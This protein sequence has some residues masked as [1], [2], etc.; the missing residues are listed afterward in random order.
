[1]RCRTAHGSVVAILLG[2]FVLVPRSSGAATDAGAVTLDAHAEIAAVLYAAS[3]T[4]AAVAKSADER[5][6]RQQE[7]IKV[8][9]AELKAGDGRHRAEMIAAQESFVAELAQRDREYA[10]QIAVFRNAVNDIASTPDGAKAL[11]RFNAGDEVGAIAILDKLRSTNE[12]MRQAQAKLEDAADARRIARLAL[13]AK[14]RGKLTT[15]AVILRFE[16]VVQLDPGVFLDWLELDRLYQDAGRLSDARKAVESLAAAARDDVDRALGFSELSDVLLAMGDLAGARAAA[17]QSLRISRRLS[18]ADPKNV[19]LEFTFSHALI[20]F[21]EVAR[22]QGDLATAEKSY[23]EE[24]SIARKRAAADPDSLRVR[25]ALCGD[26]LHLSDVLIQRG[27]LAGARTALEETLT[28]LRRMAA[29]D[30]ENIVHQRQ[31]S[32]S[33]MWLSDVLVSLGSFAEAQ[34]SNAEI[35]AIA[36]RLTAAD[37][38]NAILRRDLSYG[39][40]K[41]AFLQRIDGDF[42]GSL[43]SY[44]RALQI[45]RDLARSSSAALDVRQDVGTGLA[46]VANLK[47]LKQDF[48]GARQSATESVAILRN[49]SAADATD[50]T[51]RQ[52]Q[53][54][55]LYGLG[56]TL[57]ATSDPSGARKAYEE[58]LALDRALATK[59]ADASDIQNDIALGELGLGKLLLKQGDAVAA[60]KSLEHCLEIRRRMAALHAGSSST[61]RAVAEVMRALVDVPG[62][63]ISWADFGTQVKAMEARRIVW[64]SD[65]GWLEEVHRRETSGSA[66]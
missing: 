44:E 26:L 9:A 1:M 42:E 47:L 17:E 39:Y 7:R 28:I 22:R 6:R 56:A 49:L 63:K 24:I 14:T 45:S 55:A 5:L 46:D 10:A 51:S 41:T 33:Q 20:T 15:A 21:G 29:E 27:D 18:A 25:R 11:E 48:D 62:S 60:L 19:E 12:R 30:P 40:N 53:A 16:E 59:D 23:A 38:G 36:T 37:P 65:R 57:A 13:E 58:G 3:A 64:P 35:V 8:L 50:A 54:S 2:L 34:K 4:Q 31:I 32:V 52:F 61:E 66:P 43:K